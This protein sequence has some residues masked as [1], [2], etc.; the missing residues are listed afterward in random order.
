VHPYRSL[1][2]V[3]A[4]KADWV[5]KALRAPV[6]AI[7]LD[8]EDA[9]PEDAK[10]SARDHLADAVAEVRATDPR[11]GVVV[12]PNAS[13]TAHGA[14]DLEAAVTA[15][16]DV[17]LV[18]KVDTFQQLDRLDAVLSHVERRCELTDGR[19]EVIASLESARGLLNTDAIAT[20]PR[21]AGALAAAARDGDTAR[22]VGFR[23]SPQGLET[24]A[25]RS[26]VVLAC[27][28]AAERHPIVGLWQD[29]RD[30]EGLR[31]FAEANRDL[32]FRGQVVIHPSHVEPVNAAYTPSPE[33][34]AY[35]RGM[36]EAW[37][38]A[39]AEGRG[40]VAYEGDHVDV[41]HVQTARD[42]VAFATL[43]D[44]PS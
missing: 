26:R 11:V 29:V 28:A 5:A 9:V 4:H 30:L 1:L 15:G 21:L 17:L 42:V 41:A 16:A 43:L 8:L 35:Y 23:W 34:V 7:I 12:R 38:A 32:G 39:T 3:P 2:F 20:A 24:L 14:A 44:E 37:E 33:L 40:A 22:S 25:F 27:R 19:T 18:P 10:A 36:I 31:T 13:T 6:D